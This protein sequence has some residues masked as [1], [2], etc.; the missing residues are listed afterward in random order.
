MLAVFSGPSFIGC[1]SLGLEAARA[2]HVLNLDAPELVL[3][4]TGIRPNV[5]LARG[6]ALEVARGVVVDGH[7]RTGAADIYAAGDVAEFKGRRR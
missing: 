3:I 1:G 4:S 7:L 5:A 6:A 2:L